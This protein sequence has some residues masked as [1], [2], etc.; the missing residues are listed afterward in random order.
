MDGWVPHF[1]TTRVLRHV[2]VSTCDLDAHEF[3][4]FHEA[5]YGKN[6]VPH[7]EDAITVVLLTL[8][9]VQTAGIVLSLGLQYSD[10][11]RKQAEKDRACFSDQDSSE[12]LNLFKYLLKTYA[13]RELYYS[14]KISRREFF[15][16]QRVAESA[17]LGRRSDDCSKPSLDRLERIWL[18]FNDTH[19]FPLDTEL[20]E[21]LQVLASNEI[22][23]AAPPTRKTRATRKGSRSVSKGLAASPGEAC[24]T[25]KIVASSADVDKVTKGDIAVFHHFNPDMI[26]A[27]AKCVAS[28]GLVG[29][30]GQTGH[31][32]IV[33]RELGIPCVIG[34]KSI[35]FKD[36]MKVIVN[37]NV[38]E[39]TKVIGHGQAS[40]RP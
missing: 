29:C 34:V 11:K 2:L 14:E 17:C 35:P 30:G 37:G 39:V 12:L 4:R 23:R 9:A 21:E 33:S 13:L 10:Y 7:L 26:P 5:I 36:G 18:R 6:K 20:L 15:E 16:L 24:G 22:R 25:A 32:A 38:G 31:L 27:I 1:G 8:T 3:A 40:L 28:V 19:D